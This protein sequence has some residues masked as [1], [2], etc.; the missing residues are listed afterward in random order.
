MLL[1]KPHS[2]ILRKLMILTQ[3][4]VICFLYIFFYY[5][6]LLNYQPHVQQINFRT[7]LYLSVALV[8]LLSVFDSNRGFMI[9]GI[10]FGYVKCLLNNRHRNNISCITLV[11]CMTYGL[12][13]SYLTLYIIQYISEFKLF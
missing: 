3:F 11:Q 12:L 8:E 13:L 9:F 6:I 1:L 5:D 7:M 4:C 2:H 10:I